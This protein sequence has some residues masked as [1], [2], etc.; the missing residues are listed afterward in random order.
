MGNTD[1]AVHNAV[2]VSKAKAVTHQV[3]LLGGR[4]ETDAS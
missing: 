4:R 2:T 1:I 3:I